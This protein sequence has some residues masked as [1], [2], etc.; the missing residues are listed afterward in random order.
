MD[1][2]CTLTAGKGIQLRAGNSGLMPVQLYYQSSCHIWISLH[3][4]AYIQINHVNQR[5]GFKLCT[6][7]YSSGR[8]QLQGCAAPGLCHCGVAVH[9]WAGRLWLKVCHSAGVPPMNFLLSSHIDA[10]A[11][12]RALSEE[13]IDLLARSAIIDRGNCGIKAWR[14]RWPGCR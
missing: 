10:A 8:R 6:G 2:N 13:R 4:W 12:S 14:D 7:G 9:H 5:R 3:V 11:L 1:V